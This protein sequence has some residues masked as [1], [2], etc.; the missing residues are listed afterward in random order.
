MYCIKMLYMYVA[1][2]SLYLYIHI[3]IVYW[4]LTNYLQM[5]MIISIKKLFQGRVHFSLPF[6]QNRA[7]VEL[8]LIQDEKHIWRE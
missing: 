5:Y 6:F 2:F 8:H 1:L 7:I 3:Y 4:I